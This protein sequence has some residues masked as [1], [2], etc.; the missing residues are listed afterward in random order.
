MSKIAKVTINK[1]RLGWQTKFNYPVW[2]DSKKFWPIIYENA[3]V[4]IEYCIAVCWDDIQ[5]SD[6]IEI[7]NRATAEKLID[8]YIDT[9]KDEFPLL[10]EEELNARR[11]TKKAML[12]IK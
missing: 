12:P 5:D 6:W 10:T 1:D 4:D 9:D 7:I 8:Q 2:Y 11:V 3:W